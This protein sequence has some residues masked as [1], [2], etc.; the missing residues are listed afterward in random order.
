[1]IFM[2]DK[3]SSVPEVFQHPDRETYL[4]EGRALFEQRAE[5]VVASK[6]AATIVDEFGGVGK[7]FG[8]DLGEKKNLD[9]LS[10]ERQQDVE[11]CGFRR[12]EAVMRLAGYNVDW[13]LVRSIMPQDITASA[14][15]GGVGLPVVAEENYLISSGL[16]L[17]RGEIPPNYSGDGGLDL[18]VAMLARGGVLA[19]N[20]MRENHSIIALR[21]M[22]GADGEFKFYCHDPMERQGIRMITGDSFVGQGDRFPEA[23]A[24]YGVKLGEAPQKTLVDDRISPPRIKFGPSEND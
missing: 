20:L 24:V 7:W 1:M 13:R 21:V 12:V 14:A 3:S 18:S 11:T 8:P 2:S 15:R 23:V 10:L 4:A 9:L 17:M 5:L 16:K 6:P 19:V 22:R